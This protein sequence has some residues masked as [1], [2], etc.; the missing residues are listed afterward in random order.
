MANAM[1]TNARVRLARAQFGDFQ[2][3]AD[4]RVYLVDGADYVPDTAA[5]TTLASILAAGRV[6]TAII[7]T[8]AVNASAQVTAANTTLTGVSGDPFEYVVV[9]KGDGTDAGTFL[10]CIYDTNSANAAISVT[11]NGGDITINWNGG[12]VFSL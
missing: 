11:P 2:G 4:L 10:V 1:Y 12:V 7:G 9:A 6:A 3:A 8:V 5:H